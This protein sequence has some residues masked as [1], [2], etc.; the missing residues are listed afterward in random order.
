MQLLAV[1]LLPA[2]PLARS[3]CA[4][5][6]ALASAPI[7]DAFGLVQQSLSDPVGEGVLP[8]SSA[9]SKLV[10]EIKHLGDGSSTLGGTTA[11]QTAAQNKS[12]GNLSAILNKTAAVQTREPV[13]WSFWGI[14]KNE[15]A[16]DKPRP[17]AAKANR[18]TT[19]GVAQRGAQFASQVLNKSMSGQVANGTR[20]KILRSHHA[21]ACPCT[22]GKFPVDFNHSL[23]YVA[24]AMF[25]MEFSGIE[26]HC[27][28]VALYLDNA[29]SLWNTSYG[30]GKGRYMEMLNNSQIH[31][32]FTSRWV[33]RKIM[34]YFVDVLAPHLE[35]RRPDKTDMILNRYKNTFLSGPKVHKG[36]MLIIRPSSEGVLLTLNGQDQQNM[37]FEVLAEA[38][39]D[40]Y[41]GPDSDLPEFRDEVFRQLSMGLQGQNSKPTDLAMMHIKRPTWLVAS[42]VVFVM[43][44]VAL[45]SCLAYC[46][47]CRKAAK[48]VEQTVKAAAAESK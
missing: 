35:R 9:L 11:P 29:S 20:R 33:S 38:T 27:Y 22:Q 42:F 15:T 39:L 18:T 21:V 3:I 28:D 19:W 25:K 36:S 8:T 24:S 45:V 47:C 4:P 48:A 13:H 7:D 43:A 23:H 14:K 16:A 44:I 41:M 17:K 1:G 30:E 32:Y 6:Q 10:E 5:F 37:A 46:L 40:S 26:I 12:T 31:M 34:A 2:L